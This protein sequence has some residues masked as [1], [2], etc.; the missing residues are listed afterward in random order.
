[1]R[2]AAEKYGLAENSLLDFSANINPLGPSPRAV[3]AIITGMD[4]V[5]HYPDPVAKVLRRTVA[6]R[7]GLPE[8]MITAGNGAAEIIY[9]L[10]KVLQPRRALI[11]APT[12]SEYES[13]VR[14]N[15]GKVQDLLLH[16][17]KGFI[18][19]KED[20]CRQWDDSDVIFI[21]N[22]NNPTGYLTTREDLEEIVCK[23]GALDKYVVVDEAFMDF[24][25]GRAGYSVV[26]LV[27][28][29]DNLFVLYSL[30][31]F[32]AIPGLR[33][34]FGFGNPEIIQLIN[35]ARDPW[36]VNCFA[37][38]AGTASL[39]DESYIR[40]TMAYIS[41]ERDYLFRKLQDIKG[42]RPYKPTANYIFIDIRETGCLSGEICRMLG[43][44]G[45]LVRDCS[46]YKNLEPWYIRV[47]VRKREEND[48]LIEALLSLGRK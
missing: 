40:S 14:I 33:L 45:I 34:G 47:A 17:G 36:N 15:G 7:V 30:T 22:P 29:F 38:L 8:E 2:E 27:T 9:L 20:L 32:F 26:D 12:F 46:S 3:E 39:Q 43:A 16:E 24:V 28:G 18:L 31:K 5:T 10:M 44:R 48:R 11:P 25:A 42:F 35:Q 19:Q 21:C 4:T 6:E 23:A 41:K 37:Q 13:A 1:M